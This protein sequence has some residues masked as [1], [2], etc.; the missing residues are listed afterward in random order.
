MI[1]LFAPPNRIRGRGTRTVAEETLMPRT[2][3]TV[4]LRGAVANIAISAV[5]K[6]KTR[7]S[8]LSVFGTSDL[9]E[10]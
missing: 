10:T 4:V 3:V 9:N 1:V 8:A 6:W 5:Q 2:T 7:D